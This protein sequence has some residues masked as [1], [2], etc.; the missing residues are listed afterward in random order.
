MQEETDLNIG[1]AARQGL[2]IQTFGCQMNEYDSQKLA[3]IFE[4]S[5]FEAKSPDQADLIIINTCSVREKPEQKLYSELGKLAELKRARPGLLV[6]V[7][8]CVA[9]QE[10]SRIIKRSKVVDFV[11][12]THNL[13]LVPSLVKARRSG[14]PPQVAVDYRDGWE[15]L[16]LGFKGSSKISVFVSISRGCNKNCTY[17]IVPVTRGKEVSRPFHEIER[18]LR[19]AIHRGAREVVLLGQTVNS[20]GRDLTPRVTFSELLLRLSKI[21]GLERIRFTSPHPQEIRS[22]FV[23]MMAGTPKVCRHVHMP[24]QSGSNV[25][26]KAMNRNYRR[27]RY[28]DI[29]ASLKEAIP[30]ISITTDVIVGFPGE[31]ESDF[32]QTMDILEQVRFDS[33]YSFMF[34]ARPGTR[35]AAMEETVPEQEKLRRLQHFQRRQD[36]ITSESLNSWVGRTGEILLDGPSSSDPSCFQGRLS[37]NILVNLQSAHSSLRAGNQHR[38]D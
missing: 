15:E 13:S 8:G 29:I 28:L 3:K 27:E 17:C 6:G 38:Q 18:E 37:Q 14:L 4:S 9:Q 12:G 1:Q 21:E 26:L 23:E 31:S 10:G 16:P 19:I 35:A 24:L 11:F 30:D 5:H 33:S 36:Q 32:E 20:Y 25:I 2:Y 7:G 22:D 34:S